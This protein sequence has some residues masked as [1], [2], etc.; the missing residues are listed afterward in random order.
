L[1]SGVNDLFGSLLECRCV[2]ACLAM[3][4]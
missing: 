4:P 2:E 3:T 1:F